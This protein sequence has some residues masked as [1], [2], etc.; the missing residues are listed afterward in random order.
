MLLRPVL[1]TSNNVLASI[2]LE[3]TVHILRL[4]PTSLVDGLREHASVEMA[5]LEMILLKNADSQNKIPPK[6]T[7]G[8]IWTRMISDHCDVCCWPQTTKI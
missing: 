5:S 4:C 2:P 7:S 8:E 6:F 3:L 1:C